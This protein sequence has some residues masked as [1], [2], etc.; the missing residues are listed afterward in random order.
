MSNS[1]SRARIIKASTAAACHLAI[2]LPLWMTLTAW[3]QHQRI[4][5]TWVSTTVHTLAVIGLVALHFL[6]SAGSWRWIFG[7]WPE[8][9]VVITGRIFEFAFQKFYKVIKQ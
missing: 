2:L 3:Q 6:A 8:S 5:L 9:V 7:E 1:Q 4:P